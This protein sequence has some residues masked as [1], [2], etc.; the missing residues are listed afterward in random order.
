MLN[1][2]LIFMSF[3]LIDVCFLNYPIL[4]SKEALEFIKAKKVYPD[5]SFII[6]FLKNVTI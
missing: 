5:L 1:W 6:I 4:N 3:I 2:V